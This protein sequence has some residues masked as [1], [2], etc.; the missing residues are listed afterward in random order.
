VEKAK[1]SDGP[2]T[3]RFVISKEGVEMQ[4]R[5]RDTSN[6]L[7]RREWCRAKRYRLGQWKGPQESF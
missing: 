7:R 6:S 1:G 2:L 5:S 3:E 4:R